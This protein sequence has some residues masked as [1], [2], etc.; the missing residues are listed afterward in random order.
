[1]SAF[2]G[3]IHY[4]LYN[5]IQIQEEI[6]VL[7]TEYAKE[8]KINENLMQSLNEEIGVIENKPLEEM[9]DT[10]N[11]HGWLQ[12]K[13]TLVEKRMAKAVTEILKDSADNLEDL[14]KLVFNY[15]RETHS[16]KEDATV[17][18][19]YELLNNVL[20]DGMPCDR[21]NELVSKEENEIVWKRNRCI[22]TIYWD[23]IQGDVKYYYILR[24]ALVKGIVKE[25][26]ITFE[27][28]SDIYCKLQKNAD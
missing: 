19:A 2:L 17:N 11:I 25:S 27:R 8:K 23:S 18:E 7:L 3:P 20:L 16:L 28:F 12:E 22:H 15:G 9:I 5:K 1:M 13:V 26:N 21:V 4:W 6:V 10:T 24:D 14:E